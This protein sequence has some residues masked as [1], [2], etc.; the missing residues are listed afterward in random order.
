MQLQGSFQSEAKDPEI[1]QLS[2]TE[3]EIQLSAQ[4]QEQSESEQQSQEHAEYPRGQAQKG[5]LASFQ[6]G[7]PSI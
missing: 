2:K 7:S 5:D 4:Q 3:S 1:L 6:A